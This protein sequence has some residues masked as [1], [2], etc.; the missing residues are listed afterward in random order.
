MRNVAAAVLSLFFPLLACAQAPALTRD[1][2]RM[3]ASALDTYTQGTLMGDLWRRPDLSR[4]DRSVVTLAALI[5]QSDDRDALSD[6]LGAR[7]RRE[8]QRDF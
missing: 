4:R 5:A 1:E 2:V 7:Q 6:Q 3:V 8:A